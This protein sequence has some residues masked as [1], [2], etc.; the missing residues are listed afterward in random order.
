MLSNL[1]DC[2]RCDP[3]GLTHCST[4]QLNSFDYQSFSASGS[5]DD[6]ISDLIT[7]RID[8]NVSSYL[9]LNGT[10]F[11]GYNIQGVCDGAKEVNPLMF[12]KSSSC[13]VGV[14]P[15]RN[16]LTLHNCTDE[17]VC[18]SD[19]GIVIRNCTT[20]VELYIVGELCTS[21]NQ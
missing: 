13:D 7:L 17:I 19:C 12:E 1:T 9:D 21:N 11:H 20:C 18:S 10:T 5:G 8:L 4:S 3:D 6:V 14:G 2:A 15:D 16:H